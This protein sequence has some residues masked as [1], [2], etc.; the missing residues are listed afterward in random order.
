MIS[1]IVSLL[2]AAVAVMQW[3][4]YRITRNKG[5]FWAFVYACCLV[6]FNLAVGIAQILS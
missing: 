1:L 6:V 4:D 5:H 2:C 3:E